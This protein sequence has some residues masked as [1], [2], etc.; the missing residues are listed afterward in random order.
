MGFNRIVRMEVGI[1]SRLS[2]LTD[3]TMPMNTLEC[4]Y[5]AFTPELTCS[6]PFDHDHVLFDN[7][8][9]PKRK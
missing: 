3:L 8:C 7:E 5:G 6:C 1:F 4:V 2:R 9:V